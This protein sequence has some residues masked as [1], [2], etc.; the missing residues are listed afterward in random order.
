MRDSLNERAAD[1][2][3]RCILP[4]LDA[5]GG[6]V[7]ILANGAT[8][9]DLGVY[10]KGGWMAAKY[11]TEANLGGLGELTYTTMR[12]GTCRLPVATVFVDHAAIAELAAHDAFLYIEYKGVRRSVSGPIRS[13]TG[14]DQFAQAVDYRDPHPRKI[15]ANIQIDG[16]PDEGMTDLIAASVEREAKDLYLLAARTGTLTGAA[17]VCA[18]NVEQSLPSLLDQGFPIGSIVQASGCAP[19]PA[20]VDDEDLA[21]GRVN[22]GLLY[23]QETNLYVDCAEEEI[24]R[25]EKILP[26]DKNKDVWGTPFEE[27]FA[28]C[29]YLWRNVPREW[30]APCRVNF[31]DIR[32]GG[33]FSYG[34][35]HEGV[36]ERDFLGT[37]GGR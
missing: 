8:V 6:K 1:I 4:E 11:F 23:G 35:I 10:A 5:L 7:H 33:Q 34:A 22:D 13:V 36:L 26:F 9:I 16:L 21:Y 24:L 29:G 12:I 25:L 2:V 18:R 28:R 14:T 31:F 19:I 27:L 30:D 20:V 15:V 37:N 17:Q 3:E 32:T